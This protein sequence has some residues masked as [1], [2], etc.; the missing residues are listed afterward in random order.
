MFLQVLKTEVWTRFLSNFSYF[1]SEEVLLC[2]WSNKSF[3]TIR[4]GHF[5]SKFLNY[6]FH[7]CPAKITEGI[8]S[9]RWRSTI[10]STSQSIWRPG[11]FSPCFNKSNGESDRSQRTQNKIQRY[12][13]SLGITAGYA[14]LMYLFTSRTRPNLE[15]DA[16]WFFFLNH[17]YV[18][19]NSEE[20]S[21]L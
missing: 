14:I 15:T 2:H 7:F 5:S 11:H 10:C 13:V 12:K 8:A 18:L 1:V 17:M 4:E 16:G 9:V 3:K 19:G 21:C 6:L 20:N